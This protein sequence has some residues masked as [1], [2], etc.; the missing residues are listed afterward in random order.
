MFRGGAAVRAD[1]TVAPAS[2][3]LAAAD[4]PLRFVDCVT[5]SAHKFHGPPG[6]GLLVFREPLENGRTENG[7]NRP[8]PFCAISP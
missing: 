6:V 3:S 4:G 2:T 5:L 1:A 7:D 8:T